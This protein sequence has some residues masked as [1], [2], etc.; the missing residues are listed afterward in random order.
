MAAKGKGQDYYQSTYTHQQ[1]WDMLHEGDDY[2]VERAGSIWVSASSGMKAAREEMDTHVTSLRTQWTGAASDEFEGRM[3]LVKQY[4][5]ESETGMQTAGEFDI[6]NVGYM[7][8]R[9]HR[10]HSETLNPA[11]IDEYE[12]WVESTKNVDPASAEAQSKKTQWQQEYQTD[13]NKKHG[14]LALIVANL[15]D[16]YAAAKDETFGE[17]PPPPPSDMPGNNSYTKPTGGVFSETALD[18][19]S[20]LDTPASDNNTDLN[21]D[22]FAD[23][24]NLDPVDGDWNYGSYD[25]VDSNVAGGLA[26]GGVLPGG[27]GGG[28]S[29]ISGG[30]GMGG[31]TLAGGTGLF[32]PAQ[33]GSGSTGGR[34]AGSSPARSGANGKPGSSPARSGANGRG[35]GNGR[36]L[37]QSSRNAIKGGSGN[38]TR[39]G[40]RSGYSDDDDDETYTRETW[41][42]EDDV[43]WGRNNVRHEELDGDDER[44]TACDC[45]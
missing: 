24:D 5:V 29:T 17:L 43:D 22:G 33:G 21:G 2:S 31:S 7:H 30:G 3:N 35:T 19:S 32:G 36:G 25:D 12:D 18:S 10:P 34:G 42:R 41:L 4:S 9:T 39:G 8:S 1:L 44:L 11:Y 15:G 40:T 13:L 16:E 26:S 23:S 27:G 14:D 28:M 38:N 45:K 37:S 6:P 20:S